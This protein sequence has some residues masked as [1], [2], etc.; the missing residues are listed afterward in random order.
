MLPPLLTG[1]LLIVAFTKSFHWLPALLEPGRNAV[2]AIRNGAWQPLPELPGEPEKLQVSAGGTVWALF[3]NYGVG[4]ELARLD[5]SA[6]RIYTAADFGTRGAYA[7]ASLVLDGEEVWAATD[8]GVLHWDGR[9]WKCYRETIA[10]T[11]P[12]SIV[13]ARGK[14]WVL[15]EKGGLWHFD[16]GQWLAQ[17]VELPGARANNGKDAN[18]GEDSPELA[19]TGDGS[20][21]MVQNGVWRWDG[22]AWAAV[23]PGG[24]FQNALLAGATGEHLWL[25]DGDA[26]QS[27]APD[28]TVRQF[29]SARI[30]LLPRE[31][32]NDVAEAGGLVEVATSRGI[33][34]FDGSAWRRLA[35]PGNG[36]QA[37]E[38]I[39]PGRDGSLLAI[40]NTPRPMA[41][42]L[43]F[44]IRFLPLLLM[45]G[46][47][48]VV[49]WMVRIYK[50][51]QLD[52]HQLLQQT[53]THATGAVP[54]E[55]ARDERLLM[56]QSS[57]WSATLT[58]G[59]LAGAG[60]GYWITRFFWPGVPPCM[61][62]VLA[63]ALH[64]LATLAQTLIKRTPKPWDPIEPG[65]PRF[66]WGPTRKAIPA[67]LAVFLLM[68]WGAFPKW[69]GHPMSWVLYGG[70]ALACYSW[71]E[72]KFLNAAIRRGDYAGAL[73]IAARFHFFN[74]EGGMALERR[75]HLLLSGGRFR[76]AEEALRRA[77]A[78]LRSRPAQAH[79]LE[80][81]GD[82]LLEQGRYDEAMRAYEAA[83][84]AAPG[85]RR[86]YRGMAE[87]VLRQGRDPARALEYIEKI[88]APAGT[89]SRGRTLNGRPDDDYWAL[90]AWAL[91]E[92]GRGAEVPPAVAEAIRHT[93]PK[94][95]PEL[96]ATYRRLGLAMQA[97]DR[98]AEADDYLRKA[99]EADPQGRWMALAKA[100]LGRGSLHAQAR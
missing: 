22:S 81:L 36:V 66:D 74:P 82:A 80:F 73:R 87:M 7:S 35:A 77:V 51:R 56:K 19:A 65:G 37:V 1:A 53:V 89:P 54:E 85:F 72:V 63:L 69:M 26:L 20:L 96:A 92:M 25:W 100:A 45:L 42:R 61:F 13:A 30:G 4:S 15:D 59:V 29:A 9:R 99:I 14:V 27:V 41:R 70:L 39:R 43:R 12:S 47:L 79:A 16:G 28:G 49:V 34:E 75:G 10:S 71:L 84:G 8:E 83:L 3:W 33:L 21:W 31:G 64:G 11:D 40:G 48:A 57:W 55:F 44:L 18:D 32:I 50:R 62:L 98:Q 94:S 17:K 60:V 5:G 6:W 76:E 97:M 67:S 52:D 93:N 46:Q 68:D 2:Y 58:V 24:E 78:R 90:K 91:A 38:S 23:K 95:R 88:L 86:P